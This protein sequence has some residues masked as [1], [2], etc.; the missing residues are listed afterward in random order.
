MHQEEK[1]KAEMEA[2]YKLYDIDVFMGCIKLEI[3]ENMKMYSFLM[4][5]KFALEAIDL[6]I[7]GKK[8]L[9]YKEIVHYRTYG[10]D[11][12][13]FR[14]GQLK[15]SIITTTYAEET[16][17]FYRNFAAYKRSLNPDSNKSFFAEVAANTER[18]LARKRADYSAHFFHK[19]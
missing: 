4:K 7:A 5:Q 10:G 12:I 8:S 13:L 17:L 19:K 3:Q 9:S 2:E 15:A 1:I 14:Y 11:N 18:E 16:T 6:K